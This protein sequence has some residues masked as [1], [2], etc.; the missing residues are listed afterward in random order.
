MFLVIKMLFLYVYKP[1]R[2]IFFN[3]NDELL[4]KF[5]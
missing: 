2:V 1:D 4:L 3:K 5:F